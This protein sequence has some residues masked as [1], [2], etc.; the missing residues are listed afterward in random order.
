MTCSISHAVRV[1]KTW[2]ALP[3]S[4]KQPKCTI[5]SLKSVNSSYIFSFNLSYLMVLTL[6]RSALDVLGHDFPDVEETCQSR[7]RV[8]AADIEEARQSR[9][10]V[11]AKSDAEVCSEADSTGNQ[12]ASTTK[13]PI[14][15]ITGF[16]ALR[17]VEVEKVAVL[18]FR[19]LQLERI[20]EMQDDLL[21]LA[22][23]VTRGEAQDKDKI[24]KA[25]RN[26][27]MIDED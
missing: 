10:G 3:Q 14:S 11:D 15:T 2:S 25:L 9:E 7:E 8:D 23:A 26:Y 19:S 4:P 5:T 16:E 24:D 18:S 17:K 13:K 12:R 21:G 22:L 1:M 27:G 20:A 6:S